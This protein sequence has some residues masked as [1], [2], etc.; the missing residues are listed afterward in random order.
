MSTRMKFNAILES[1][2]SCHEQGKIGSDSVKY[3]NCGNL[4]YTEN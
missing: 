1:F 4:T 3:M 2:A